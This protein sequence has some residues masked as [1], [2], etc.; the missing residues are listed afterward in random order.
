[1]K[2]NPKALFFTMIGISVLSLL[3]IV[4]TL[5]L[6]RLQLAD[7]TDEISRVKA[8]IQLAQE[9]FEAINDI[10]FTLELGAENAT[11]LEQFIPDGKDQSDAIRELVSIIRDANVEVN[12]ITFESTTELPSDDSQTGKSILTSKALSLPVTLAGTA[13]NYDDV[14][15]FL[16]RIE[17]SQRHMNINELSIT[18]SG[19]SMNFTM[20]LDIVFFKPLIVDPVDSL[21]ELP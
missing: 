4:A 14:Y 16:R 12:P 20:T 2:M 6:I 11:E 19:D 15:D 13:D 8:D 3:T 17:S 7:K 1:M 18:S 10:E 9:E 5:V 21:E